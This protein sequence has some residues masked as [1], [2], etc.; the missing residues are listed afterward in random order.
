MVVIPVLES[1]R[2]K[3]L[4]VEMSFV[5]VGEFHTVK[6]E[7]PMFMKELCLPYGGVEVHMHL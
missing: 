1:A 4:L 3:E 6:R 2:I 7:C 5:D